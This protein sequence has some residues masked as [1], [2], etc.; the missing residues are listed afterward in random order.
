MK[1]AAFLLILSALSASVGCGSSSEAPSGD[2]TTE[3]EAQIEANDAAV[4]EAE[5]ALGS[6]KKQ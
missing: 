3:A 5:S 1:Y 6:S 2:L 4:E